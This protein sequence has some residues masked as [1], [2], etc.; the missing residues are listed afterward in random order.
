M[1]REIVL[2]F[3]ALITSAL[4][5]GESTYQLA[6][7]TLEVLRGL[8]LSQKTESANYRFCRRHLLLALAPAKT[9]ERPCWRRQGQGRHAPES[10]NSL[11]HAPGLRP[12]SI[13]NDELVGKL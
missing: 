1:L 3:C 12:R 4:W 5:Q 9:G 13:E 6:K 7:K 8:V 10:R 11:C 2:D